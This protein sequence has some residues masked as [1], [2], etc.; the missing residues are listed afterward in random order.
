M[1]YDMLVKL[2]ALED[3]IPEKCALA[4]KGV[5]VVRALAPDNHRV[6]AFV[7]EQFGESWVSECAVALSR[8]PSTCYIAV[9]E[10]EVVGFACYDA[11]AKG[12]FGPTGVREDRRGQD[13]GTAL[14]KSCLL[15]MRA[16]GYGYAI[17]GS[18]GGA[19]P[20]YEKTVGAKVIEDSSPGIYEQM[21]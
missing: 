11:P 6:L 18:V 4:E 19:R 12:F 3:N 1:I 15:A 10:H 16:E 20:F 5:R 14:L 8:T 21:I 17:I 7:R 13:I 2:Y 9:A